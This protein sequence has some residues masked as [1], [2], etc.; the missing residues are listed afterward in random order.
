MHRHL[1]VLVLAAGEGRRMHSS[2]PKPLH[3]LNEKPLL[4]WCLQAVPAGAPFCVAVSRQSLPLFQN[5]F[6]RQPFFPVTNPDRGPAHTILQYLAASDPRPDELL[7]IPA[8]LPFLHAE[9]LSGL[10]ERRRETGGAAAILCRYARGRSEQPWFVPD[11]AG[12]WT[13]WGRGEPGL[14]D[15][16]PDWSFSGIL[17]LRPEALAAVTPEAG[18]EPGELA[19]LVEHLS[20][21]PGGVYGWLD[22]EGENLLDLDSRADLALAEAVF[23]RET[24]RRWMAAGVTIL[25][26]SRTVIGP[27]AVF[28]NDIILHPGTAIRG[29]SV[30]GAGCEILPGSWLENVKLGPRVRVEYSVIR[31]AE[32][33][34]GTTVGPFAHIRGNSVI[35][36]GNRIGNFVEVKKTTTGTGTK[37]AHLAYLGDAAIGPGVNIGAGTITCNYDGV[38]KNPTVIGKDAFIGS[39]SI[40]VAPVEIGEGAYVGA[41]STITHDVPPGALALERS[42]QRNIEG[43]VEKRRRKPS[44]GKQG[45]GK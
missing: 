41:G 3:I 10:A 9:V 4:E 29:R 11:P 30:I 37:A 39:D 13:E 23:Q 38:N 2:L 8:D 25:D 43:W 33:G 32:I 1:Q 28:E 7:I 42:P 22:P 35:G 6:P 26:P 27:D 31:D 24:A 16:Q 21:A 20:R 19:E 36:A 45:P 17:V 34:E 18:R 15:R 40:L 12:R 44:S 5:S 14:Q